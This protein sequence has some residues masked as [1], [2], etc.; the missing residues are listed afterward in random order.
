M[1]ETR[2]MV[3]QPQPH[4]LNAAVHS[5]RAGTIKRVK[6]SLF[7][8]FF[9]FLF[10][11]II[12]IFTNIYM[13]K[14]IHLYTKQFL[15]ILSRFQITDSN[16]HLSFIHLLLCYGHYACCALIMSKLIKNILP[17]HAYASMPSIFMVIEEIQQSLIKREGP[18]HSCVSRP[19]IKIQPGENLASRTPGYKN[20]QYLIIA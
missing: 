7:F 2:M 6:F 16:V 9:L 14:F 11:S 18:V 15:I 4:Y 19:F 8:I 20:V 1:Q 17:F 12:S 13:T 10:T 5:N 3:Q